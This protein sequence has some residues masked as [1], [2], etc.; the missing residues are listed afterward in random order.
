MNLFHRVSLVQK[1][2]LGSLMALLVVSGSILGVMV[3]KLSGQLEAEAQVQQE[4]AIKV[5]WQVLNGVGEGFRV[6]GGTFYAGA[7]ALN[8]DTRVVDRVRDLVG[9]TATIFAGD[10]R[11]ATNVMTGEGARA[12]GT[13]LTA[14]AAYDAVLRDGK[15][16]R[17]KATIQGQEY[18]TAYDPIKD[19]S[20]RTVGIL[21]TGLSLAG[22]QAHVSALMWAVGLASAAVVAGLGVLIHLALGRA[23]RPLGAM[24]GSMARLAEGDLD[25]AIGFAARHDE[26]GQMAKA[27]EVFRVNAR[28]RRRLE[29]ESA[30]RERQLAE[31]RRATMMAMADELDAKVGGALAVVTDACARMDATAQSLSAQAEETSRQTG[32]VAAA[33]EQATASVQTVATASEELSASIA[34]IARQIC[35]SNEVAR[36]AAGDASHAEALVRG[37]SQSSERIGAVVSLINDIA[38]QTNLLALNATIEAARA[39]EAGKGFAV[40]AG[41]VKALANQTAKATGEIGQQIAAVQH[42]TE[43]V[44]AGIAEI[45]RRIDEVGEISAVIAAAVEEQSAAANEIARN[46]HQAAIGTQ[47]IADNIVGVSQSAQETGSASHEVLAASQS[48][49]QE[50]GTLKSAVE[51]F[52]REVR[53]AA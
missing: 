15:P 2:A 4:S 18:L 16:Y 46:V 20:G 26:I 31:D 35:Q 25:V 40:V 34:E 8:G 11:I 41:E 28:E 12:T 14:G 21:Y 32:A 42:A 44:V 1:V 23:L 6:E 53:Q 38:G 52:L 48:L 27:L 51:A 5:A 50:A 43:A 7:H 24:T 17:G 45:V 9:G 3:W 29:A 37:L 49:S 13:R 22:V 39:G 36:S 30:A 47:E 10:V 33:T 19:A